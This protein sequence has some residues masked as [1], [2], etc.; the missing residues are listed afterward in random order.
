MKKNL[1][2]ALILAFLMPVSAQNYFQ[3]FEQELNGWTATEN[4]EISNDYAEYGFFTSYSYVALS[5][6]T[7]EGENDTIYTPGFTFDGYA[8]ANFTMTVN[9][10]ALLDEECPSMDY[11]YYVFVDGT[12]YASRLFSI[13]EDG[14]E[15]RSVSISALWDQLGLDDAEHTFSFAFIHLG[16]DGECIMFIDDFAMTETGTHTVHFS[17]NDATGGSMSSVTVNHNASYTIPE[18]SFEYSGATFGWWNVLFEDGSADVALPNDVIPAVDG[19]V[20]LVP[21]FGYNIVFNAN[22]GTG[23][24][25]TIF[26]VTDE[27]YITLPDCSFQ[28][29]GKTFDYWCTDPSGVGEKAY[30]GDPVSFDADETVY[31]IWKTTQSGEGGGEGQG[32]GGGEGQG[33]GG[34]EGQGEGGGEGGGETQGINDINTVISL[35]PNPVANILSISGVQASRIEVLDITGRLVTSV[36]NSNIVDFSACNKGVYMMRITTDNG[37]A[38]RRV[39]KK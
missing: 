16:T 5:Y 36:E 22:G 3:N 33:E 13:T 20:L 2:F 31:A 37:V 17:P 25:D 6:T 27:A 19:H 26:Y 32:E 10:G 38:V 34:G 28:Y 8:D 21:T 4:W 35:Y 23:A 29:Q 14:F 30:P 7:A 18:C 24:N 39:V 9:V 1:F 12:A 15:Q 11:V